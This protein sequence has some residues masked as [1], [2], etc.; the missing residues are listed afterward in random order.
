[1]SRR[2]IAGVRIKLSSPER[3]RELSSGEEKKP[4]TIK[5]RT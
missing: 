4:E 3:I 5:Y 1:M 2:E